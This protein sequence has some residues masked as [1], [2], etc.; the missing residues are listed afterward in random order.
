M[1]ACASS[2]GA[3]QG[4][5]LHG[6]GGLGKSTLAARLCERMSPT[7]KRVVWYGKL[8]ETEIL[9]LPTKLRS[10]LPDIETFKK[11]NAILNDPDVDLQTRLQFVLRGPMATTPC[12]FVFDNFEDGNVEQRPGGDFVATADAL[13]ILSAFM[14]AIRSTNSACRL[15]ITSRYDFALPPTGRLYAEGMASMRGAELEKKLQ[16]L[17]ALRKDANTQEA[18]RDR[19]IATAAGNPRLLEWLNLI[20]ADAATDH[21][22]ILSAMEAKAEAFREDV[23]AATLLAGQSRALRRMLA[24]AQVFDLPVPVEAVQAVAGADHVDAHLGRAEAL[25]LIESGLDPTSKQPRYLVSNIL[26]P[27]LAEEI[28]DAERKAACHQGAT[29]LHRLWVLEAQD[30]N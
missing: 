4:T 9:K 28:T 30:A 8:D 6:M 29:V 24:L 18:L 17:P 1:F 15:I 20:V 13:R 27:L 16:L 19:A 23:L 22:A 14:G 5:L 25:G 3:D 10:D 7:H 11:A 12:L 26:A 21:E 2:R